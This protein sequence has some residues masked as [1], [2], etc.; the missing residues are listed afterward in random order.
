[1]NIPLDGEESTLET[2][3]DLIEVCVGELNSV[4]VDLTLVNSGKTLDI[5][6]YK[7]SRNFL[8][9]FSYYILKDVPD[10]TVFE[11]SLLFKDVLNPVDAMQSIYLG[12]SKDFK[13]TE[14][15]HKENDAVGFYGRF[16][17][18][19]SK[20]NYKLEDWKFGVYAPKIV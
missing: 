14:L 18:S 6:D 4:K 11:I 12:Y 5:E 20:S 1:M 10:K 2:S 17:L 15:L 19:N 13:F 7:Y 3:T 16:K 9:K 8:G